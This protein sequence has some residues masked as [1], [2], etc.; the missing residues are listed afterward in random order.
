MKEI[1]VGF[2]IAL[3]VSSMLA[4]GDGLK[5]PSGW[6]FTMPTE[7]GS[8]VAEV[9]AGTFQGEVL[10]SQLPVLCEFVMDNSEP[11]ETMKPI[12]NQLSSEA[13]GYLRVVKIDASA[14]PALV[15]RYKV[16]GAP[17]FV[18]FKEGKTLNSNRGEMTKEE[19]TKWVKRELDMDS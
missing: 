14:N 5:P 17:T 2:I 19:L 3:I 6:N 1:V 10:D 18:L 9:N 4:S 12:V 8:T 16:T 13:Q 11:C 15:D 7:T